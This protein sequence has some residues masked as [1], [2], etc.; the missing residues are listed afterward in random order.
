MIVKIWVLFLATMQKLS[1]AVCIFD[2]IDGEEETGGSLG[3]AGW[4]PQLY[5]WALGLVRNFVCNV[6][7]NWGKYPVLTSDLHIY[8]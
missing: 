7:S 5:R 3:I 2:S 1:V 8:T 6:E 4:P